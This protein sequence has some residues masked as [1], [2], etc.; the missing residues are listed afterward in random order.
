MSDDLRAIARKR[1]KAKADF[2]VFLGVAII[3][4]LILVAIWLFTIGIPTNYTGYFWPVWP[5]LGLGIALAFSGYAAYG[6]SDHIT[7]DAVDAEVERLK[8]RS[9]GA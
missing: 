1:L 9:G 4:A 8:R 6:P 5:L 2:K 7:E 3:V